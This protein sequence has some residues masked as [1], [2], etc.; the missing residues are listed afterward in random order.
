MVLNNLP[1]ISQ[2]ESEPLNIVQITCMHAI[3]LIKYLFQVLFLNTY[4]VVLHRNHHFT[5]FIPGLHHQLQV[6][7]RSFILHRIIHEIENHIRDVHFICKDYRIGCFQVR[8]NL[9]V[10]PFHFQGKRIDY[11]GNQFIGIQLLHFQCRLLPV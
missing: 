4:T 3:E 5:R 8:L 11:T 7:I 6:H 2:S 1:Y 9:P 10:V